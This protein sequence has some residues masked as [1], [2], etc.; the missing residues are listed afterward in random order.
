MT[1]TEKSF[2]DDDGFT[3]VYIND[4]IGYLRESPSDTKSRI[5]YE[6]AALELSMLKDIKDS[7]MKEPTLSFSIFS[8]QIAKVERILN[9]YY[10]SVSVLCSKPNPMVSMSKP[11][12]KQKNVWT[13]SNKPMGFKNLTLGQKLAALQLVE[14]ITEED[15]KNYDELI[16]SLNDLIGDRNKITHS[17]FD[18]TQTTAEKQI[19]VN[20]ANVNCKKVIKEFERLN[21]VF[22]FYILQNVYLY[23]G[24]S[25]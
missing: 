15:I 24:D 22:S 2:T 3:Y 17:L 9:E 5:Y 1:R 16:I 6:A 19:I 23:Y 4:E 21:S 20:R 25:A 10:D 12:A 18:P 13:R 14:F 8:I 7:K 11:N